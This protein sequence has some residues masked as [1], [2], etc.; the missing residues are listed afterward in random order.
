MKRII[1]L[2]V[3]FC[4]VAGSA[5]ASAPEAALKT[6]TLGN[7]KYA[8]EKTLGTDPLAVVIA[9][10]AV[11]LAPAPLFGLT[12][13]QMSVIT[14][15][16]A[17]GPETGLAVKDK[18][19]VAPLVLVLGLEEEAVWTV[20]ANILNASPDLIHAVLKGL[21]SVQGAVVDVNNGAVMILGAHP[22]QQVLVGRYLLGMEQKA[23]PVT[24]KAEE[25][26]ASEAH[27]AAVEENEAPAAPTGTDHDATTESHAA[28]AS[29]GGAGPL[30]IIAFIVALVGAVIFMDK[31]VLKP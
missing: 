17:F 15:A 21:V 1:L 23:T 19:L 26:P 14:T 29:S 7:Q 28:P 30:G 4:A 8:L 6:L 25:T 20:Y 31:T 13:A 12:E 22:D 9:D 11:G 27:G 18:D 16:A 10:P 3:L 24:V 2:A 5:L